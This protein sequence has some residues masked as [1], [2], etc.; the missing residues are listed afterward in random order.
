VRLS[1]EKENRLARATA[2]LSLRSARATK[3]STRTAGVSY[4]TFALYVADQ[5]YFQQD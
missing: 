3:F 2:P 1:A 4:D 5:P